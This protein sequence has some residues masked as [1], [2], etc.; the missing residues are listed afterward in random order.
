MSLAVSQ[1]IHHK[2]INPKHWRPGTRESRVQELA[3]RRAT[4]QLLRVPLERFSQARRDYLGWEAFSLWIRAI[5]EAEGRV[6]GSIC[7]V[8]QQRCPGFMEHEAQGPKAHRKQAAPLPLLLLEWIHDRVFAKAKREGWLDA[9]IF[10]SV[11]HPYSERTWAYWEHCEDG[12][13]RER[14]ARY[15][16]F[17]QWR[18]A[19]ENWRG[20]EPAERQQLPTRS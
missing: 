2:R 19:A 18:L 16:S 6:P 1:T 5:V 17:D 11:R 3:R 4:R 8:L 7:R 15:P 12:W 10:F 20:G 13:K 14:P 9:L